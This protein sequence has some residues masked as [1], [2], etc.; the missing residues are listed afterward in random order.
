M[1]KKIFYLFS[2]ALLIGGLTGCSSS[3]D[4]V[5]PA[6]TN[7]TLIG[8]EVEDA[9]SEVSLSNLKTAG[10]RAAAGYNLDALGIPT[11]MPDAPSI[12]SDAQDLTTYSPDRPDIDHSG[13]FMVP[14]GTTADLDNVNINLTNCNLYIAG[15]VTLNQHWG[16]CTIHVL[17]GGTL[18]LNNSGDRMLNSGGTIYNYG[19]I[20]AGSNKTGFY[21]ANDC[22]LY[23]AGTLNTRALPFK[24]QGTFY[25]TGDMPKASEYT[26]EKGSL[27]NVLGSFNCGSKSSIEGNMHF[28]GSIKVSGDFRLSGVTNLVADCALDVDG[29]VNIDAGSSNIYATY[30]HAGKGMYQCSNSK[31]YLGDKGFIDVDG[32]YNNQNNPQYSSYGS[33]IVMSGVNASAVIKAGTIQ[34]NSGGD[35]QTLDDVYFFQTPE[36][37]QQVGVDCHHFAYEKNGTLVDVDTVDF[38]GGTV[39]II[40]PEN[41]KQFSIPADGCHGPGYNPNVTPAGPHLDV[42]SEQ[43]TKHTHDISA[44]C[45]QYLDGNAYVSFHQRGK[46]QS[47][48][49]E[50]ISTQGDQS[51]LKQFIRDHNKSC[52]FNHLMIDPANRVL[53]TVGNNKN[54]GFM[55]WIDINKDGL[56]NTKDKIVQEETDSN[57]IEQKT[58]KPLQMIKLYQAAANAALGKKV[59]GANSGDGNA[60]VL[61]GNTLQVASTYGLE[62]Y[63]ATTKQNEYV[64][65][66]PGKA[67]HIC[68]APDGSIWASYFTSQDKDSTT[69]LQLKIEHF[70]KADTHMTKPLLSFQ[71]KDGVAPNNGKNVIAVYDGK[72][73]SC[74]GIYGLYVYDA[75]SGTLLQHYKEPKV[76][77]TQGK[78][79]KICANGVAVDAKYVYLAYGTR[80]LIVLDR[81]T[82]KEVTRYQLSRSA[83]YVALANGYI[84]VAYG[85]NCLKVFKLVK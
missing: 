67:K 46:G 39:Q 10:T 73:Y 60:V 41:S 55:G 9:S 19:T 24:V 80:G 18:T 69:T 26:F 27:T 74:Q 84:Y 29:A 37:G 59:T 77:S 56:L 53:Y 38:K 35:E 79:L 4:V 5:V 57:T 65:H 12:P 72:V 76:V 66:T 20:N 71:A 3:D 50:V 16:N 32:T 63:D 30:I 25:T 1:N 70:D 54:G 21:V 83:N 85:R 13:N 47:G 43:E 28:G 44:T 42:I 81:S 34:F 7:N 31:I 82:L 49:L 52:D 22:K 15:N 68:V 51:Q 40:Y 11:T 78:D 45:V 61:N 36:S 48:C 17:K 2:A 62:S 23:N 8:S 14:A 75:T 6:I 64:R 33:A 58:Y